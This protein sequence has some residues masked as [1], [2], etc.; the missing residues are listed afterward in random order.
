[1]TVTSPPP[2]PGRDPEVL[3]AGPVSLTLDEGAIRWVMVDGEEAVR[4]IG[5][6]VRD[7]RWATIPPTLTGHDV[8]RH[9]NAFSVRLAAEHVGGGID[10][11]W[12]GEIEGRPDGTL[13]FAMDGAARHSFLRARI[14]LYVLHG[15][16]MAGRPIHATTPWGSVRARL[17]RAIAPAAPLSMVRTMSWRLASG[18]EVGLA[19]DGDLWEMEDQRNFGDASFKTYSTPLCIPY[20]VWVEAGT[21]VAQRITLRARP[22]SR[23]ARRA[24][25]SG[26]EAAG[27]TVGRRGDPMP[28]IGLA[29]GG[30]PAAGDAAG[31]GLRDLGLAHVRLTLD[32]TQAGAEASLAALLRRARESGAPVELALLTDEDG[33]GVEAALRGCHEAGAAPVRVL[34]FDRMRLTTPRGAI[35]RTRASL[36]ALGDA[37]PPLVGGS[38]AWF[39]LV[40]M[41]EPPVAAL[42]G[43]AWGFSPRAHATDDATVLENAETLRDQVATASRR[44]P[45]TPLVIGPVGIAYPFDPW[46]A[47]P[48]PGAPGPAADDPR[49]GTL[50][51]AAWLVGALAAAASPA[52]A[53]ITVRELPAGPVVPAYHVLADVLELGPGARRLRSAAPPGLACLALAT[54]GRRRVLVANL[55]RS[56]RRTEVRIPGASRARV[57]RL[58]ET[59]TGPATRD[60]AA[61]RRDPGTE[62]P[63]VGDAVVLELA[64]LAIAR[65]DVGGSQR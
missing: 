22:A 24:R 16:A 46:A 9:G 19:F 21:R 51:G 20:P 62:P 61:F 64:P 33:L 25:P 18:G 59:T 4:G 34:V 44:W 23:P 55:G 1:V 54:R 5:L 38:A 32:T 2:A 60:P 63:V 43:L 26:G 13:R 48:A 36:R 3:R 39:D 58:D 56:W 42:D 52:V 14:G 47:E 27:V 45:G 35:A 65:I 10:F 37:A 8:R 57:R 31:G 15:A 17:P 29:A 40:N 30:G 12:Q 53:A 11:A 50:L 41:A 7:P 49:A 28:A 6:A